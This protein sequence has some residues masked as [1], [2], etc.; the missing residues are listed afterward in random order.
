MEIFSF[1]NPNSNDF[2][3][4][5]SKKD[6]D[7]FMN[8]LR[9]YKISYRKLLSIPRDIT[10]GCEIE[11]CSINKD[12]Q[13]KLIDAL[14]KLNMHKWYF[15]K[16][17]NV[18][19]CTEYV[20]PI[21]TDS[22]ETWINLREICDTLKS[23]NAIITNDTAGHIHYGLQILGNNPDN[24]MNFIKLWAVYE[25]I[26]YRFSYGEYEKERSLIDVCARP[27]SSKY[28]SVYNSSMHDLKDILARL[29]PRYKSDAIGLYNYH[30]VQ[31]LNQRK[32]NMTI[33][34]RC[35]NSSTEEVIWQNNINFFYHL[36][37]YCSSTNFNHD[38]IDKRIYDALGIQDDLSL[39]REIFIEE[40]LELADLIFDNNLDKLN[41]LRQYLKD[42]STSTSFVKCKSFIQKHS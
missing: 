31:K 25:N 8:K 10:F 40:A 5:F 18:P 19:F 26:I 23:N 2:L 1:I 15:D 20:S 13:E 9:H 41:F 24:W 33:E 29:T 32:N 27:L 3:S 21:L 11:V 14:V 36:L 12:E 16:E 7:E 30:E 4:S 22:K 35:P 6:I 28:L 38:V 42:Y 39:Y 37:K 17:L 34:I